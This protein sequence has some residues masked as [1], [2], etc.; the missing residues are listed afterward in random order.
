MT[1]PELKPAPLLVPLAPAASHPV[2]LVCIPHAGA[3]ATA[4][5]SWRALGSLA[6]LWAARFPGRESRLA[7]PP[8]TTIEEMAGVLA[9]AVSKITT[10]SIVLFGHCSGAL[11]A[12]ELASRLTELRPAASD[13]R[14]VLS[15][16]PAPFGRPASAGESVARIS[17]AELAG[18]LRA[19]G[20]TPEAI[21]ENAALMALM[22]PV[23]RADLLAAEQYHPPA[24][25]AL[26][27]DITV[28][29]AT[30]DQAISADSL[31]AWRDHTTG[32]FQIKWFAG[33]HFF[34]T[35]NGTAVVEYLA[36]MLRSMR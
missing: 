27:Y 31:Q 20:G 22:E 21:L 29:A 3:G 24:R 33:Q 1:G 32:T 5:H 17:M 18:R 25:E 8:L 28:L 12:Y 36:E 2:S 10:R 11:V 26:P 16:R 6:G 7:E 34:V 9:P 14:L 15:A 19:L 35:K 30:S 23:I 13:L 4:F